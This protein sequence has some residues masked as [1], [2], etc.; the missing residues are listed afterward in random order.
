MHWYLLVAAGAVWAAT[1]APAR[2]DE[3]EPLYPLKVGHTWVYAG[4]DGPMTFRVA[5]REKVGPKD[6]FKLEVTRKERVAATEWVAV[7]ADGVYRLRVNEAVADPPIRVLARPARKGDKWTVDR[8]LGL[9][10]MT[11]E[12]RVDEQD[13]TVP[14][15]TFKG[16]TV[17][18][19]VVRTKGGPPAVLSTT[20]FARDVGVV[21][22][23]FGQ[24][25]TGT[26]TL[27][28]EKFE[29]GK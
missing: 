1:P 5:G 24:G 6:A 18:E 14:A 12:F 29:P 21:K 9:P 19:C 20:W 16:A 17:V 25:S 7:D 26:P 10:D 22:V 27:E 11:A 28:L 4:P 13:V 2:A 3:A 23:R 15:G 8:W